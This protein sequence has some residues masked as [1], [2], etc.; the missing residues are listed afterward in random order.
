[1]KAIAIKIKTNTN[2]INIV[3][4]NNLQIRMSKILLSSL[5]VLALCYVF[6]VGS[7]VF[8]IV[9]RKSLEVNARNLTNEVGELELQYFSASGKIDS[10]FAQSLGFKETKPE[11]ATRKPIAGNIKFVKN[12]L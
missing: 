6:L 2:R 4:N 7:M 11:Y 1:M 5:G 3:N 9:E 10:T 12:E 8:N